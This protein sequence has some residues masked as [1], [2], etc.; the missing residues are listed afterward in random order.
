M[1]VEE[2]EAEKPQR[3]NLPLS[4]SNGE[5]VVEE[6]GLDDVHLLQLNKEK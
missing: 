2:A 5:E 6:K 1:L 4:S 3:F